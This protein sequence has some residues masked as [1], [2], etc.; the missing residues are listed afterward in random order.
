MAIKNVYITFF[1]LGWCQTT[2]CTTCC[3]L[4]GIIWQDLRFVSKDLWETLV[5]AK[6]RLLLG[7]L[8]GDGVKCSLEA[9]VSGNRKSFRDTP[10]LGRKRR[11]S[12]HETF[13]QLFTNKK[14]RKNKSNELNRMC[15]SRSTQFGCFSNIH[16]ASWKQWFLFR[17]QWKKCPTKVSS[18]KFKCWY[19][20]ETKAP[21]V[22]G[23]GAGSSGNFRTERIPT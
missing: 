10:H 4:R 8:L 16:C 7:N 2:S 18:L 11:K 13:P 1:S 21:N 17:N 20:F 6:E 23:S 3:P 12:P 14:F 22:G 15:N 5:S 9:I 19:C